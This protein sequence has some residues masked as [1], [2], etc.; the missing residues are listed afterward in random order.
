V[1]ILAGKI[2]GGGGKGGGL[3]EW[4]KQGLRKKQRAFQGCRKK[5]F[6]E[7]KW[8][9]GEVTPIKG[10]RRKDDHEKKNNN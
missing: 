10:G 8:R 9:G 3:C 4:E 1:T 6:F 5:S 7:Q 2:C